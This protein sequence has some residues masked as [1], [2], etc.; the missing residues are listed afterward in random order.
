MAVPRP[1]RPALSRTRAALD[2]RVTRRTVHALLLDTL[3][4]LRYQR[5]RWAL[6]TRGSIPANDPAAYPHAWRALGD[7]LDIAITT[8]TRLRAVAAAEQDRLERLNG[9][10]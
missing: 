1:D 9:D 4:L 6:G 7:D 2:A 3:D 5:G 8:L 10:S